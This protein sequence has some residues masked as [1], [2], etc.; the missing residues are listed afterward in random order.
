VIAEQVLETG[1]PALAPLRSLYASARHVTG[2]APVLALTTTELILDAAPKR[3]L[4]ALLPPRSSAVVDLESSVHARAAELA[5][6]P[7]LVLRAI[8]DEAHER[9]PAF[10]ARCRRNDGSLERV[11]IVARA[12]PRP[13]SWIV[14]SRLAVRTRTCARAIADAVESIAASDGA[15]R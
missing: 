9:L 6:V 14:L 4:L 15:H 11:R 10:L 5:G 1:A 2:A 7:W 12:M 3:D 8:S 13:S